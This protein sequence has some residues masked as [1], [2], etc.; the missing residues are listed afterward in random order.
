MLRSRRTNEQQHARYGTR[1]HRCLHL[2][3]STAQ[4]LFRE[5]INPKPKGHLR[6]RFGAKTLNRFTAERLQKAPV[7]Y[8]VEACAW[9]SAAPC[10]T[11]QLRCN[12]KILGC[13]SVPPTTTIPVLYYTV[14]SQAITAAIVPMWAGRKGRLGKRAGLPWMCS[15]SK[16][17]I[18]CVQALP[19]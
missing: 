14:V 2:A 15:L 8:A 6:S 12:T 19:P 9:R 18:T 3:P 1:G 4:P 7:A 5:R 10:A 13:S 11:E 16:R 17:V